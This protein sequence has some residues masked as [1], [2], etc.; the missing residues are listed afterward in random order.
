MCFKQ[1]QAGFV[2]KL[3]AIMQSLAC[4]LYNPP[5]RPNSIPAVPFV[6]E[7]SPTMKLIAIRMHV[8]ICDFS[9]TEI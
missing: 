9:C 8:H 6:A 5:S 7:I 3:I 4:S 2:S 1:A